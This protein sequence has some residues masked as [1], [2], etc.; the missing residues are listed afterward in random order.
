MH[1]FPFS[2]PLGQSGCSSTTSNVLQS[3]WPDWAIIERYL[4]HIFT[5][6]IQI[7]CLTF[8][9]NLKNITF[10]IGLLLLLFG[11][12][13]RDLVTFYSNIWSHWCLCTS[14]NSGLTYLTILIALT[15]LG[16][17]RAVEGRLL[18]ACMNDV[19][20]PDTSIWTC[21]WAS[22]VP[23]SLEIP[24]HRSSQSN[25]QQPERLDTVVTVIMMTVCCNND[26]LK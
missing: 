10:K 1:Q 24:C 3:V 4:P 26:S 25:I 16:L 17:L 13:G 5:K 11:Q 2:L 20:K 18:L 7:Y 22:S 19:Y 14:I 12:F 21:I 23:V 15:S 6:L 9:A 8:D